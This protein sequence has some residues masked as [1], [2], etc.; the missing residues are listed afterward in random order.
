[1]MR[2]MVTFSLMGF[3]K[4]ILSCLYFSFCLISL[5]QERSFKED[6]IAL[7]KLTDNIKSYNIIVAYK[8]TVF[9]YPLT[10]R[11]NEVANAFNF[12]KQKELSVANPDLIITILIENIQTGRPTYYREREVNEWIH[13][14]V[15]TPYHLNISLKLHPKTGNDYKISLAK[16]EKFERSFGKRILNPDKISN[17]S[18][19]YVNRGGAEDNIDVYINKYYSSLK[20]NTGMISLSFIPFFEG[21]L[22][23]HKKKSKNRKI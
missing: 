18:T 19:Y 10:G 12:L 14:I 9:N 5:A 4:I 17:N 3:R 8:D 23:L 1:M 16:N 20:T 15:L 11:R 7:K 21:S 13:Y 6:Y 2:F 22:K